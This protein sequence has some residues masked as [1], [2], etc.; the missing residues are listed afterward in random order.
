MDL[1]KCIAM[2]PTKLTEYSN[3]L[4]DNDLSFTYAIVQ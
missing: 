2:G 1:T 4:K 3:L